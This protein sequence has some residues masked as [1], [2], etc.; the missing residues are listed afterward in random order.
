MT[1]EEAESERSRLAEE[2][3]DSTWL[4]REG[5]DGWQVLKVGIPSVTKP[6]GSLTAGKPKP[7]DPDDPRSSISKNLGGGYS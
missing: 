6:T 5:A 7:P 1:R 2:Q 3:P 4:V